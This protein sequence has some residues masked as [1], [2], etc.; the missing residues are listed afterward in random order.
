LHEFNKNIHFGVKKAK[1]SLYSPKTEFGAQNQYGRVTCPSIG[2]FTW[3]KKKY[4]FESHKGENKVSE[5]KNGA[6]AKKLKRI[7]RTKKTKTS[8]HFKKTMQKS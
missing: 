2:N 4:T 3:S 8:R 7:F 6:K 1:I 5:P